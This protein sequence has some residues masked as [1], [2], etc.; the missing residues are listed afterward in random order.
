MPATEFRRDPVFSFE[1]FIECPVV[2]SGLLR[3]RKRWAD[4]LAYEA[5]AKKLAGLFIENS[6][7]YESDLDTQVKVPSTVVQIKKRHLE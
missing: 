1:V 2:P 7:K 3:P 5:S 4:K 6:R